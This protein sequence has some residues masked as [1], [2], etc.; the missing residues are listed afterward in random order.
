VFRSWG[1]SKNEAS[2][3]IPRSGSSFSSSLREK[4]V[5]WIAIGNGPMRSWSPRISTSSF[6]DSIP[7]VQ[8]N[9]LSQRSGFLAKLKAFDDYPELEDFVGP[10]M[11]KLLRSQVYFKAQEATPGF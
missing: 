11:G 9:L 4:L 5:S 7:G 3:E 6:G 8:E 10:R 2:R 1:L